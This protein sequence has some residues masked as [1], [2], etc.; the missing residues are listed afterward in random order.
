MDYEVIFVSEKTVSGEY[1]GHS[2]AFNKVVFVD[3]SGSPFI[4]KVKPN[5]LG[6]ITVGSRVRLVYNKFGKLVDID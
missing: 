4:E 2:Y 3:A 6:K 1:E 5:L